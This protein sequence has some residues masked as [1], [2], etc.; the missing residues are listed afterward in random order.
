MSAPLAAVLDLIQLS[1]VAAASSGS[2]AMMRSA[3]SVSIGRVLAVCTH[4]R[5]LLVADQPVED[6]EGDH[7]EQKSPRG[8][9][10]ET[11]RTVERAD[12]GIEIASESLTVNSETTMR[13]AKNTTAAATA[14]NT[15]A[16]W[17]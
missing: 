10:H 1:S 5:L 6:G 16:L 15:T 17:M 8:P 3:V 14:C 12:L 11:E 9:E 13:V 4:S 2:M 7:G